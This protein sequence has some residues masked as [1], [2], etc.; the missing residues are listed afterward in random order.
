[1][2]VKEAGVEDQDVRRELGE[3]L[4]EEVLQGRM[5][6]RQLMVRASVFGLSATAIGSLLAACGSSTPST[7]ASAS[8]AAPKTGG[9]MRVTM[10]PPS[11][12]PTP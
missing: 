10:V 7:S 8:A 5:T 2:H 4:V 9:T 3:H 12:R 6:R 11:G 1:M